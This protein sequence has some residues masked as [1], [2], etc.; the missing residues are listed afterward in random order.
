MELFGGGVLQRVEIPAVSKSEV[1]RMGQI[2]HSML[3]FFRGAGAFFLSPLL[4][5]CM[6]GWLAGWLSHP[7][8]SYPTPSIPSHPTYSI[9]SHSSPSKQATKDEVIY[10]TERT[11]LRN[12]PLV[13]LL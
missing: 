6:S 10:A 9:A 5:I 12:L 8:L 11:W 1:V 4:P 2:S 7:S 13:C 3:P